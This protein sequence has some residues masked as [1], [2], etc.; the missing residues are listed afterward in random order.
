[1]IILFDSHLPT[2]FLWSDVYRAKVDQSLLHEAQHLGDADKLEL[3]QALLS[4][5]HFDELPVTPEEAAVVDQRLATQEVNPLPGRR[6]PHTS[7]D[8]HNQDA[9]PSNQRG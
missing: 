3:A 2:A 8:A 1:M 9:I 7:N 6:Q 4:A 5:V